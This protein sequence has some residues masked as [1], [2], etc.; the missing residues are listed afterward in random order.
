MTMIWRMLSLADEAMVGAT[1]LLLTAIA[2]VILTLMLVLSIALGLVKRLMVSLHPECTDV[3]C[4][5]HGGRVP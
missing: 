1:M 2:I 4:Q 3:A 5:V